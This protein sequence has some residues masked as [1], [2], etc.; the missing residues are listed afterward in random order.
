[1]QY[2]IL[3]FGLLAA[4][5]AA[6]E[7][8][9]AWRTENVDVSEL[10]TTVGT[11]LDEDELAALA[12]QDPLPP[13]GD[14]TVGLRAPDGAI[15]LGSPRGLMRR[16]ADEPRWRLFHSRR[17]L[18]DNHVQELAVDEHGA[19]W[20]QTPSGT[21]RI[22]REET[23]LEQKIAD[24]Q[25]ELRRSNIRHGLVGSIHVNK[26]GDIASGHSQSSNDNDGLWTSLYV[27]A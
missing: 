27:S 17:W 2:V 25:S 5:S 7:P 1:M 6:D 12:R 15:W 24:I 19:A 23:T 9:L 21:C 22:W 4:A 3:A 16:V 8:Y 13:Y 10:P 18:P 11:P 26:P 14:A 20:V